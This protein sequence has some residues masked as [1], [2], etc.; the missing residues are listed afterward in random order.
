MTNSRPILR[1]NRP[2]QPNNPQGEGRNQGNQPNNRQQQGGGGRHD[3]GNRPPSCWLDHPLHPNGEP[4]HDPTASFVEYLRW[5]RQPQDKKLDPLTQ[6]Q[7]MQ[8][9]EEKASY[10]K[11]LEVLSARTKRL[12]GN[13]NWFEVTCPWRIRVG[14]TKG[15]ESM[16]LPTFDALGMPYI[17]S[18]TLR[19]IARTY[20]IRHFMEP[21]DMDWK[22]SD[23][24]VEQWFGHLEGKGDN[25]SGKI[26]FFDAY[27]T[28]SKNGGL[29]MDMA[30]SIW[31]WEGDTLGG[32]SP[33]PNAFFSLKD[34]SFLIGLRPVKPE[35]KSEVEQVRNWLIAGLAQGA[36]SQINSGYG[37][38]R[39]K[40]STSLPTGFFELG[41]E[42]YGQLV[43][44][45]KKL[46]SDEPLR[47]GKPNYDPKPSNGDELRSVAI[48]NMMRYWFRVFALG[49]L[50]SDAVK[51]TEKRI[52]GGIDPKTRGCLSVY[53]F[54]DMSRYQPAP[55]LNRDGKNKPHG[56]QKGKMILVRSTEPAPPEIK[57][58]SSFETNLKVLAKELV[59][60]SF[61]LGGVGQGARRPLYS[62]NNRRNGK[63]PWWRGSTLVPT[64]S[65]S[66]KKP[67][68]FAKEFRE[69]LKSFYAA[70]DNVGLAP[71][72]PLRDLGQP[73]DSIWTEA[74]DA[75]CQIWLV[76]VSSVASSKPNPTDRPPKPGQSPA[77]R[78]IG[79][80][81]S[82]SLRVLHDLVH[83]LLDEYQAKKNSQ[84]RKEEVEAYQALTKAKNLCGHTEK[85]KPWG[86]QGEERG[87]IPSPIWIADHGNYQVVTMFGATQNPRREF[88]EALQEGAT[89]IFPLTP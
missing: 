32:Y 83:P 43:H 86:S 2:Q 34:V 69:H 68:D 78:I 64:Y 13:G 51:T 74:A 33:N 7:I 36:G 15:P 65:N 88:V 76:P 46:K 4:K 1:P 62:R 22:A 81:K 72:S 20:A 37:F 77:K 82:Q 71:R 38:A 60:L 79:G 18:S 63:P 8:I 24:H 41:F 30:N 26:I 75:H 67:Q 45:V 53:V 14:G 66:F 23:R 12:A 55:E 40:E 85:D 9:A 70:L 11:R 84:D 87:A 47:N 50:P 28:P 35:Y 19:G 57:D 3:G 48:K 16:L 61:H 58:Q 59:W 49:V 5:M 39:E 17:P 27:P 31:R 80:E 44:S 21:K 54:E 56:E 25:R 6:L 73:S 29:A 89:K 52:F 10:Q 42:V